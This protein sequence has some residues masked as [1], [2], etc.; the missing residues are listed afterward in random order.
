MI[1]LKLAIPPLPTP[2]K[3][4]FCSKWV[5][6]S[7]FFG[8]NIAGG[9]GGWQDEP[10]VKPK[11]VVRSKVLCNNITRKGFFTQS[12]VLLSSIVEL[13]SVSCSVAELT[14]VG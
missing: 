6:M 13:R 4:E 5:E 14:I 12:Q 11:I 1:L 8:H 10:K 3:V 9:V 2:I 7:A